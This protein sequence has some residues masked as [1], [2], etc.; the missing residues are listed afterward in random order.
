MTVYFKKYRDAIDWMSRNDVHGV[1]RYNAHE[2]IYGI[3]SF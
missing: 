2:R 1:I 3:Y